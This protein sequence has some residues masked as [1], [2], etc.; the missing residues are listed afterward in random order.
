M[1]AGT[2]RKAAEELHITQPAVSSLIRSLELDTGLE[3]FS[4]TSRGVRAT[5]AAFLLHQEVERLFLSLSRIEEVADRIRTA[6][7]GILKLVAIPTLSHSLIPEVVRAF[8]E[9]R[10]DVSIV[11]HTRSSPEIA[12]L[13]NSGEFDLGLCKASLVRAATQTA[14]SIK[15]ACVCAVPHDHR[16]ASAITL[17]PEDLRGEPFVS[18]RPG[19]ETRVHVDRIFREASVDRVTRIEGHWSA[20][21]Y[22]FVARGLGV[23]ILE[24]FSADEFAARGAVCV[25]FRPTVP[26]TLNIIH[27]QLPL[28]SDLVSAFTAAIVDQIERRPGIEIIE[29]TNG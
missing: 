21:A 28:T 1:A 7:D 3:L 6:K 2:M 15:V 8:A 24:P 12:N 4:R 14:V 16:L 19:S 18:L 17:T 26:F 23:S 20:A 13:V 27:P 29:M 5:E 22:R 10:P 11:A 25:P 9:T